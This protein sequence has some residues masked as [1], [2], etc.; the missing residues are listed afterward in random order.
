MVM[1]KWYEESPGVVSSKRI[2]GGAAMALGMAMKLG[3]YIVALFYAIPDAA[4]AS[5]QADGFL[6]AGASLLGITGI[7]DIFKR[8]A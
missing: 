8:G 5:A 6:L 4:T 3:L 7:A 2:F 1:T